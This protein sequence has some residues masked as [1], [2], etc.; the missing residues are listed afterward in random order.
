[1]A[2]E[3][4]AS[5]KQLWDHWTRLHEKS[6]FYDLPGFKAGRDSLNPTE[7]AEVG[8]VAGKS[9]LHLQCHFGMDTLSW[10]RRG[11]KVTGADLSTVAIQLARSL[12]A[13]L[14]IE[15]SFVAANLYDL[16]AAL[17]GQFDIIYTG[18]GA[19]WWLP[20]M[21]RWGEVIAHFLKPGGIFY[22][23]DQHPAAMAFEEVDGRLEPLYSYWERTEPLKFDT[24]GSYAAPDADHSF[25]E[26]GWIHSLGEIVN[27]L[28]T[29]GLHI[30]FLH[31]W[32]HNFFQM[33]SSMERD[34]QRRWWLPDH[35]TSIPMSFSLRARRE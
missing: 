2:D 14:G 32:P 5:N 27:A 8:D 3:Y 7:V 16:P 23:R 21:A 34:E 24:H 18:G 10:A 6:E 28:T 26:Y 17:Q 9:L 20:D 11:A 19:L 33:F 35:G 13:E 1:M 12:S 31:E 22:V 15:A 30:E 29:Q 25:V 4:I